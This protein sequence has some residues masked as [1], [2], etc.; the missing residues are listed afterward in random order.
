MSAATVARFL[1][2]LALLALVVLSFLVMAAHLLR[3]WGQA[4][5]VAVLAPLLLLPVRRPWSPRIL[6]VLL[7]LFALEWVRTATAIAEVRVSVGLPWMRMALI[8][9]AV[10]L[11]TAISAWSFEMPPLRRFYRRT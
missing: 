10:A 7:I 9:G 3:G 6:Q 1:L 11:V 2:S 4:A 5:A 8:L